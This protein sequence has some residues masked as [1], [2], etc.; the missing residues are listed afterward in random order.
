MHETISSVQNNRVKNLVRLREASH[1]RRQQRFLIEGWRELSRAMACAW[2]L[3]T[4]FFC[5]DLFKDPEAFDLLE[6]IETAGLE[7]VRMTPEA[8]TKS[9]YRQSPDGLLATGIQVNRSL[10]E[11]PLSPCPLLVILESV[12]KPGNIGAVL[13]T[14]SA[15]GADALILT[16]PVTDPFNPN[17]IRA[18]QGA[19]FEVPFSCTDTP[20]L[21]L[22]LEERGIQP[23]LA[24][25]EGER[26][27]WDADLKGP[28]ALVFGS[29]DNGLSPAWRDVYP[30]CRLPMKG[31]TD[32][33]NVSA[34]TAICLFEAVRQRS[35][36]LP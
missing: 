34:T 2:P 12:E 23:V 6:Q 4:L 21:Q 8:F 17:V 16:D 28:S 32:S 15:A 22:F 26:L 18:S 20:T 35:L 11:L 13:R 30:A 25:P 5:E 14:V 3:E 36:P 31:V 19:F 10:E 33:L 7:L 27:F 1:R 29:E 24:S 9:A